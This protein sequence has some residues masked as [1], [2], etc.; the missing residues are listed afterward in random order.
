[1]GMNIETNVYNTLSKRNVHEFS[2][3]Q[4][5]HEENATII[6]AENLLKAVSTEEFLSQ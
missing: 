6:A 2:L 3:L 4:H 5:K 1:M